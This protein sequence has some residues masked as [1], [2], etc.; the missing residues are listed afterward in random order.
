MTVWMIVYMTVRMLV[1]LDAG[2]DDFVCYFCL[3]CG[4]MVG[5]VF[6]YLL[7]EFVFAGVF[8]CIDTGLICYLVSV[9]V[10]Y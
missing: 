4:W 8:I 5:F 2:L 3:L 1:P 10:C 6:G 7:N 9:F